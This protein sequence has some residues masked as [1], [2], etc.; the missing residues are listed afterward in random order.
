MGLKYFRVKTQVEFGVFLG[1]VLLV[2]CFL[3]LIFVQGLL[4]FICWEA[5]AGFL[6]CFSG[7]SAAL[8]VYTLYLSED[9]WHIKS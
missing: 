6:F 4:L 7:M 2:G 3:L 1:L 5:G 8:E 9:P